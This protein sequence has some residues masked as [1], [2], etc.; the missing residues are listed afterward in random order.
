MNGI[1]H[2]LPNYL[3]YKL[4][5]FA[6]LLKH[7]ISSNFLNTMIFTFSMMPF[8]DTS[9]ILLHPKGQSQKSSFISD[10]L[11]EGKR[12]QA[13]ADY[14]SMSKDELSLMLYEVNLK[15]EVIKV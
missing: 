6:S 12:G 2:L 9:L 1:L 8:T 3:I 15:R 11:G 4:T 13:I 5:Y 10:M 14:D 7:F